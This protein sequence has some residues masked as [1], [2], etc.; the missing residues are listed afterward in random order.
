[1]SHSGPWGPGRGRGQGLGRFLQTDGGQ[2]RFE[3]GQPFVGLSGI[4]GTQVDGCEDRRGAVN[5]AANIGQL[6]KAVLGEQVMRG[7]AVSAPHVQPVAGRCSGKHSQDVTKVAQRRQL[8][9]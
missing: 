2:L 9:K 7:V 4:L 8:P 1:M 3:A 6:R 5:A